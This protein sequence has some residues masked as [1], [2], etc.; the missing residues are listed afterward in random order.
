[1]PIYDY[2]CPECGKEEE[3]LVK[4]HNTR[5]YCQDCSVAKPPELTIMEKTYSTFTPVFNGKGFHHTDYP[6]NESK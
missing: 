1:M 5:V 2:K 6:N 3:H 4:R